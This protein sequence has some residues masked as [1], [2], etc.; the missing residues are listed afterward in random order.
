MTWK[1]VF[2]PLS[3][4]VLAGV[5]IAGCTSNAP[6][7]GSTTGGTTTTT[8][9]TTSGDNGST[10]SRPAPAG[11][12]VVVEGNE[13]T[14]GMVAS[15]GGAQRPWGVDCQRGGELAMAELEGG[16]IGKYTIKLAIQDSNSN[17]AEGKSAA[18]KLADDGAVVLI[19]E[20]ASG[21][22]ATM[23]EVASATGVPIVAVGATRTDLS[24]KVNNFF[25]V[26]Y[27]DAFQ[28][29]VMANFAYND[30][31][32][33]KVAIVTDKALP[34]STGLSDSF[35][36]VFTALGGEIVGEEFYNAGDTQ[37]GAIVTNL[38]NQSPDGLFL[39]G[40]FT[41]VG[42]LA[43]QLRAGGVTVP[44]LGGDGWDSSDLI[45]S[46]GD[47][48]VGG[49]FCNHYNADEDRPVVKSFLDSFTKKY[50]Q[51]PATTM[52]ALG[53]DATKLVLDALKRAIE[54]AEAEGKPLDTLM[55]TQAIDETEN[56]EGVSGTITLKGQN[57][58]PRKSALVV[59]VTKT[60]F[61]FA[62]SFKPEEVKGL[63]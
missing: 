18:Q 56:F 24:Q 22:T 53:Y 33:K 50:G 44:L 11:G 58:D 8:G 29:P 41:E 9:G 1:Q 27:T 13:I 57:G 26:C 23:T 46:G 54:K 36:K 20:V 55:I 28:G 35:R 47:A 6:A 45:S 5:L 38:K 32:L 61:K 21:I 63:E 49:Y 12:P 30:L 31:G 62:K 51:P 14:L 16:K 10:S 39:S 34:Y 59:E 4:S 3:A 60:G 40:Y 37:F 43:R 52:A 15:L 17:P 42:P 25:R 2:F 48:I 7:D 19:G